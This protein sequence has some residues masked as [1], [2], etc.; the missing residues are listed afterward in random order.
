M[1]WLQ[2]PWITALILPSQISAAGTCCAPDPEKA[3]I[4]PPQLAAEI[5]N[6]ELS[7]LT[8]AFR[9]AEKHHPFQ[10]LGPEIRRVRGEVLQSQ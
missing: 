6:C 3:H 2:L 7:G 4:G 9:N 1:T 8:L 5:S 10:G